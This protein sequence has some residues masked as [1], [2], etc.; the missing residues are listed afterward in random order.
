MTASNQ[1]NGFIKLYRSMLTWEWWDDL[2]TFRLFVTIL[3]SVNWRERNWHGKTIPRG[4]MFTSLSSLSKKSGLTVRQTRTSLNR[5]ISTNEVTSEVTNN[6]R[7]ITLVNYVFYQDFEPRATNEM[8]N[9][10]TS[11]RQ[12]GDK[13]VTTTKEYKESKEYKDCLVSV[14]VGDEND[15]EKYDLWSQ[16]SDNDIDR[17]CDK[18]PNT[19]LTLIGEVANEVRD[20]KRQIKSPRQYILGYATR[21]KWN[22]DQD[23][24]MPWEV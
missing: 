12:S 13:Q 7:L 2:N 21:K 8:T 4:A 3:L 11:G 9:E 24:P 17:I 16:L 19:G 10:L 15:L 18:Y 22:D 5:L 6:G 23:E 14:S 1:R 20:K